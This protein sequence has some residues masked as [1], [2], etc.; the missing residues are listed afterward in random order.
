[1]LSSGDGSIVTALAALAGTA[2]GGFTSVV[3][4]WLSQRLQVRAQWFARE[5][6]RRQVLY[7]EFIEEASKCYI[8]ALQHD[9]ADIPGLVG[10]YAKLGRMRVLSS[11][12]V[13][14][15]ADEIAKKILDTYLEP[16][17][18]FIELRDM[19][20]NGTISSAS[21]AARNSSAPSISS[22]LRIVSCAKIPLP[23]DVAKSS[24]GLLRAAI[25]FNKASGRRV[26]FGTMT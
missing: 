6:N 3:A 2:V 14:R 11:D 24:K 16:D 23:I 21:P 22:R 17:K 8:D 12:P 18:S 5:N 4:G 26:T 15:S 13:V 10:L 1:V 20:K 9:D 7:R 25:P 19:A